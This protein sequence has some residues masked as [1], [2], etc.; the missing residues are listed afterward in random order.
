[1]KLLLTYSDHLVEHIHHAS[2][3]LKSHTSVIEEVIVFCQ[4]REEEM[5]VPGLHTSVVI[6][7]RIQQQSARLK[8]FLQTSLNENDSILVFLHSNA[9]PLQSILTQL[10]SSSYQRQTFFLAEGE[11]AIIP[12]LESNQPELSASL[13]QHIRELIYSG[14]YRSALN[15]VKDIKNNELKQLISFGDQLFR[16]DFSYHANHGDIHPLDLLM[17]SLMEH[18]IASG[19]EIAYI[20][21]LKG[22]TGGGQKPFLFL[23][24]NYAEFLYEQKDIIDFIVLYYRIVEETLLFALGWDVD[25]QSTFSKR[26]DA[27][28]IMDL[29]DWRL[30]KHYHRYEQALRQYIRRLE[31]EKKVKIRADRQI[32]FDSL[33]P[34][35]LYF[36]E[37]YLSIR[38]K[39]IQECLDFRH[40]GVSG[41]G[42]ADL[43]IAEMEIICGGQT[44]LELLEPLLKQQGLL[45]GFS[46]FQV[47]NKA[48]LALLMTEDS[49]LLQGN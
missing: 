22:V 30:T 39:G 28:Y 19:E 11:Q 43:T 33:S 32:G 13:E 23:L 31:E 2:R 44:P 38:I 41:H 5:S 20:Q 6:E 34:E 26:E 7:G 49:I 1:M 29:P 42:F 48:I 40:E 4:T 10:C 21:E 36:A 3:I 47:L 15:L 37:L 45:P 14:N 25:D 24:Q 18:S 27:Q 35:E 46:I 9:L 17:D 16:L 8:E 12:F